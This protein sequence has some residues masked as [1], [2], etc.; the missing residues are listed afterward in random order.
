M[1][2]VAVVV[3]MMLMMFSI[4]LVIGPLATACHLHCL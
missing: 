2:V 3:V 4:G 1:V